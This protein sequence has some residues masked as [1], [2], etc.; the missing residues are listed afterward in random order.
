MGLPHRLAAPFLCFFVCFI[1]FSFFF[2]NLL[3]ISVPLLY[4]NL[5]KLPTSTE[6][7]AQ[8]W[9]Q[10]RTYLQGEASPCLFT[11]LISV[12]LWN[13]HSDAVLTVFKKCRKFLF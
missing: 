13:S 12:C 8:P 2:L 9:R 3:R 10:F 6:G 7:T 4:T 1:C 5:H 11:V